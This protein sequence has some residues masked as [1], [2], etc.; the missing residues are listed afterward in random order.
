MVNNIR[1]QSKIKEENVNDNTI[2]EK[3]NKRGWDGGE[4]DGTINIKSFKLE[5][6]CKEETTTHGKA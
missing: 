1:R 4:Y 3:I 6:K 5:G 2:L